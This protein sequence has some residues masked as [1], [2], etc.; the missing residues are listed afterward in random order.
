[1][2]TASQKRLEGNICYFQSGGPTAVINSSFKGLFDA[3]KS[4]K[5]DKKFF[6]SRFGISGLL[7]GSL[8]DVSGENFEKLILTPGSFPGSL[9][10]KLQEEDPLLE[11]IVRTLKDY[12]IR[13]LFAN[14]G[15][16]SMDTCRK[17]SK[18]MK[19]LGYD[20]KVMGIPKTVDND[21]PHTDHTPGFGSAAKYV[22]NTV[23]AIAVDDASYEK[24]RIN[25]I[26]VMG[27]DSGFLTAS[28]RLASLRGF[29]PDYIYV[30][31]AP[32]DLAR[33]KAKWEKTFD[34]R[35][36]CLVVV[37]EGIRDK[38]GVLLTAGN[39]DA[40]GNAQMGG[41]CSF[42]ASQLE[43]DGYRNRGIE[44][45]LPQRCASY[46]LSKTDVL[47]A[48]GVGATAL[49]MALDGHDG[50]MVT[51]ERLSSHPY[52]ITYGCC[53]LEEATDSV[54]RLPLSYL[55]EARDNIDDGYLSYVLPLIQ[56][57][58]PAMATDGLLDIKVR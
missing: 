53:T 55:N 26:E 22:A 25:I 6:V 23:L 2:T 36:H 40:F 47:E 35:K 51:I 5:S 37:S 44:L 39:K 3:Y 54:V 33:E 46:L 8:E 57:E 24:G 18:A 20:C 38:D 13:Y 28:A 45:S 29:E 30:P 34:E 1:M 17:L 15:N 7:T 42:L 32:F 27:R 49:F 21:L 52:E 19:H 16:D 41:V 48:Q 50:E 4:L 58:V 31:E 43:K 9:R 11:D 56:G 12:D 14:G 10:K